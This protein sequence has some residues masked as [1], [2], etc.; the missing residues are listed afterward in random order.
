M[1][2][3]LDDSVTTARFTAS[4]LYIEAESSL[5]VTL[6]LCVRRRSKQIADQ[7]KILP[8]K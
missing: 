6:G 5:A 7:I 3:D 4:A 1:H 2:L 8:Y